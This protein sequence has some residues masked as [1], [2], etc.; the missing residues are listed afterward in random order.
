MLRGAALIKASRDVR[1]PIQH[2]LCLS[3]QRA[4][5]AEWSYLFQHDG[6]VTVSGMQCKGR[7]SAAHSKVSIRT[8][9]RT[10]TVQRLVGE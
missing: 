10:I 5:R 7:V 1:D 4:A 2:C 6:T 3:T 9:V 8:G